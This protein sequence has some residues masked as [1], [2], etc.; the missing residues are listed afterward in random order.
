MTQVTVLGASG[1]L[2]SAV[3]RLLLTR[4][5]RVRLVSRTSPHRTVR[6]SEHRED[7]DLCRIDLRQPG[8]VEYAVRDSDLVICL[9]AD[10]ESR[11]AWRREED[12]DAESV[13]LGV[14][15]RV[16]ECSVPR[17]VL[18]ASTAALSNPGADEARTPYEL[19]KQRAERALLD[20]TKHGVVRGVSLRFPSLVGVPQGASEPGMGA[21]RVF[22]ERALSGQTID[23]WAS[24]DIRRNLLHV[25]DAASAVLAAVRHVDRIA[26]DNWDV[27]AAK[28]TPLAEIAELVADAAARITGQPPTPVVRVAPPT[29]AAAHDLTD[30]KLEVARFQAATNWTPR[31][32]AATAINET[33][34]AL[35]NTLGIAT[36]TR[37][38]TPAGKDIG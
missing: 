17:S 38:A 35:A 18:F 25:D 29:T 24:G 9:V 37:S 34:A 6:S 33:V 22:A 26:G 36:D 21:V 30:G 23:L 3:S 28:G 27:G 31:R 2:G 15:E 1:Y 12:P 11:H 4:S 8:A 16:I 13:D 5:C 32:S 20:A 10:L 7:I 19:C 14:L